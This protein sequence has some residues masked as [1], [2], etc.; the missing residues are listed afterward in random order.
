MCQGYISLYNLYGDGK[1]RV[2]EIIC[3]FYQYNVGRAFIPLYITA[4]FWKE[5][6]VKYFVFFAQTG[7]CPGILGKKKDSEIFKIS[8]SGLL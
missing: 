7:K 3:V 4:H 6:Y 2:V 8:E 5:F 1:M